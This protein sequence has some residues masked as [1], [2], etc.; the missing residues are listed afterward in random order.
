MKKIALFGYSGHAY[1]VADILLQLNYSIIGYFDKS[2]A[3]Y[4]PFNLKYLGP[5]DE[6]NVK[7]L[8]NEGISF[9]VAIGDNIV[10]SKILKFLVSNNSELGIAVSPL[11]IVSPYAEISHGS[12]ISSGACINALSKIGIGVIIN[13]GAIIEHEC[14]IGDFTHIAPGAV[15]AGNVIVGQNSFIGANSVIKQGIKIGNN[16]VVG[17]GAVVLKD[18]PDN[19]TWVGNPAKKLMQNG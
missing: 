10:R 3:A 12:L 1:V 5:E 6:T 7:E 15:L 19:E 4:N 16:V 11:A 18:I 8:Q 2:E 14:R 9:F 13:T 17:A